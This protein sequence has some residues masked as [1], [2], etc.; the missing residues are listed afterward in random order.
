MYTHKVKPVF[1]FKLQNIATMKNSINSPT[2]LKQESQSPNEEWPEII[3]VNTAMIGKPQKIKL[4]PLSRKPKREIDLQQVTDDDLQTVKKQ[5]PFMYYSIP[6]VRDAELQ[7]KE[8][9]ISNLRNCLSCAARMQTVRKK[10]ISKVKRIA[11]ISYECHPDVLLEDFVND[12]DSDGFDMD[13]DDGS[14]DP[15]NDLMKLLG[16]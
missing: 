16:V 9:D 14:G 4:Q 10:S 2:Y 3:N 11:C 8:I 1:I 13:W 12:E 5:D 15:L 6:G 7:L